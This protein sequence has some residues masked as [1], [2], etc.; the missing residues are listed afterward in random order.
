MGCPAY[1]SDARWGPHSK[2][3]GDPE[4]EVQEGF[5]EGAGFDLQFERLTEF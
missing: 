2:H 5:L 4:M 3:S 1:L